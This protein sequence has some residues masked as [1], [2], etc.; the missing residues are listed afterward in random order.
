MKMMV[1]YHSKTGNTKK[2]AE[3]IVQG[4]ERFPGVQANA[5]SIGAAEEAWAKES[6]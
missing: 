4:M 3:V 1:L 6:K 5:C 2:M